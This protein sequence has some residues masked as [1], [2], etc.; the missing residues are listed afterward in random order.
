[1]YK[2]IFPSLLIIY[3]L[4]SFWFVFSRILVPDEGYYLFCARE[5]AL[6]K[7]P[8]R[9]FFFPQMPLLL[10]I[11]I[12]FSEKGFAGLFGARS[13]YAILGILLGVLL[14]YYSLKRTEDL[15]TSL[16]CFTIYI[17]NGFI[18]SWHTV[19]QFNAPTDLILF[20]AFWLSLKKKS[21]H[22][23]LSGILLGIVVD[24]RIVFLPVVILFIIWLFLSRTN[25]R[26]V[27]ML[28]AG[29]FIAGSYSLYFL[30]KYKSIFL[31]STI[32]SQLKRTYLFMPVTNPIFQKCT[33]LLKFLG[34]PQTGG[35]ILLMVMTLLYFRK[36]FVN[37]KPELLALL[38]GMTIFFTYLVVGTPTMFYYFVQSLP[39][40]LV[41]ALPY[42]KEQLNK[43]SKIVYS[44]SL[45]Y[46]IFIIIP[47]QLHVFAMRAVDRPWK[48][49]N[50]KNV[51][52]WIVN[53]TVA[54]DK[55]IS[56]WAGFHV[57]AKR[58]AIPGV[59][60]W[61]RQL[62]K[63]LGDKDRLRYNVPSFE[64]LKESISRGEAPVVIAT[65]SDAEEWGV[66]EKYKEVARFGE[67]IAY[68]LP[69]N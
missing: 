20:A 1:M 48:M 59:R 6:G 38:T 3:M 62:S 15:K 31:F 53:N 36:K 26:D 52:S 30:F 32:F 34:F 65:S 45:V 39:F 11:L 8:Y 43:R 28:V 5:L 40:L 41:A 22:L 9:D 25:K 29:I 17:F 51:V 67:F 24:L 46:V 58:D 64:R 63:R 54:E 47:I 68:V 13:I 4:L 7:I 37:L 50:I 60:P 27:L 57:L 69:S 42:L 18:L 61:G 55:I 33:Q 2:R 49:D 44:L 35:I 10:Y 66:L 12:P 16:L 21:I 56:S 23:L 14:F 19:L